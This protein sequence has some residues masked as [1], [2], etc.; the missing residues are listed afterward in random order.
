M[1]V[2]LIRYPD[3]ND[4]MEAKRRALV[5][6][7]KR[8]VTAPDLAWKHAILDAGHSPIRCLN[9]SFY[10]EIPYWLSTEFS[11]HIHAQ[12][13]IKSQR[14]DR[15]DDYDRNAAR[16]DAPVSMIWDINAEELIT[17]CH[18]RMCGKATKE[19]QYIMGLMAVQV[20]TV[21]PEFEFLLVPMCEYRGG[22]CHEI[23]GSCGRCPHV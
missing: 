17:I 14:N 19:A 20:M 3:E 4:W 23:G 15:Q 2:K 6:M 11:R 18:K 1:Q 10:L 5:T 16:Q 21:C 12:P 13:Y 8:P 22:K 7:G 9:F